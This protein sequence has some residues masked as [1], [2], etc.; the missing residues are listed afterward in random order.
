MLRALHLR[1]HLAET[2]H[3]KDRVQ[4]NFTYYQMNYLALYAA[5]VLIVAYRF[6][7]D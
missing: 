3:L 7:F 2:S 6:L 5:M 4:T 1:I